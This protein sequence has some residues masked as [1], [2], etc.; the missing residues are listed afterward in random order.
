MGIHSVIEPLLQRVGGS[1][2]F[3]VWSNPNGLYLA[4]IFIITDKHAIY[5]YCM[6]YSSVDI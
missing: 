3:F 2:V 6:P 4:L 5:C 1:L